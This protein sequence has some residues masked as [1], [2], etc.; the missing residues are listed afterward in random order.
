MLTESTL[1]IFRLQ[2]YLSATATPEPEHQQQVWSRVCGGEKEV[3]VRKRRRKKERREEEEE[4][5]ES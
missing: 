3:F 1:Q 2:E 4:E 5:E